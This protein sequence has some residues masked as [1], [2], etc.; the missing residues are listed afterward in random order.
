MVSVFKA[1]ETVVKLKTGAVNVSTT[2]PL[3]SLFTGTTEEITSY[4]KNVTI[5]PPE[6]AVDKQDLLGVD[7][8][9]FQN[10]VMDE[11][12]YG[13]AVMTG[14]LVLDGDTWQAF[15]SQLESTIA[16]GEPVSTT[17]K[18]YQFGKMSDTTVGRPTVAALVQLKKPYT[19]TPVDEVTILFNNAKMTKIGDYRIG[20]PDG[21]WEVDIS[22]T[23]LPKDWYIEY[24][25]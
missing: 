8:K 20:G 1:H 15:S 4:M 13:M 24:K 11:K 23:C 9:G 18:R 17:H 21:H 22:L 5:T 14:T 7:E 16:T 3:A 6:G 2:A 19:G 12:P 25:V 10:A